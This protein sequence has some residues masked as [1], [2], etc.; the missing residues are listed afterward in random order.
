MAVLIG[1][2]LASLFGCG[3]DAD[4]PPGERVRVEAALREHAEG[5]ASGNG[6][7]ACRSMTRRWYEARFG[8]FGGASCPK[9]IEMLFYY[10][11]HPEARKEDP[12][13]A[14]PPRTDFKIYSV[15]LDG[16]R[17]VAV[18]GSSSDRRSRCPLAREDGR[19]KV[20]GECTAESS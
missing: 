7:K 4:K 9:K 20:D 18:I 16:A 1:A 17:A 15:H 14:E 13:A 10:N 5:I 19:W 3:T 12:L 2:I 6:E 11:A 8:V